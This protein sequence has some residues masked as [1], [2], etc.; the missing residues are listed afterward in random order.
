MK[1]KEALLKFE[2]E[3]VQTLKAGLPRLGLVPTDEELRRFENQDVSLTSDQESELNKRRDGFTETMKE[4]FRLARAQTALPVHANAVLALNRKAPLEGFSAKTQAEIQR[5]K[6]AL[7]DKLRHEVKIPEGGFRY[8]DSKEV[9]KVLSA[10]QI[11]ALADEVLETWEQASPPTNLR[12]IAGLEEIALL[13]GSFG[14]DFEG[15]IEFLADFNTYAIFCP[16]LTGSPSSVRARFSVAHELAHYYIPSH[17]AVLRKGIAHNTRAGGWHTDAFEHQA[18]V[19]AAALLVPSVAL[20]AR[21]RGSAGLTLRKVLDF[22]QKCQ[23]SAQATA[24]R[25]VECM[26]DQVLAVVSEDGRMRYYF[27][28]DSAK[29]S[30]LRLR[31]KA[32]VPEGPTTKAATSS[33][34]QITYGEQLLRAWFPQERSRS[35]KLWEEAVP[36][37]GTNLVLTLLTCR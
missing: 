9:D 22:A 28:S 30:G 31:S 12:K 6:D 11:E 7:V 15:R 20:Q 1:D 8:H 35:L 21:I 27:A 14:P 19:F 10:N 4:K 25:Y 3:M 5:L 33:K 26:A 36:L 16:K 24:F 17:R 37:R 29:K 23:A 32:I 2:K 34:Q 13:E 18:D